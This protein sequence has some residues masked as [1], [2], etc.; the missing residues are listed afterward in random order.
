MNKMHSLARI[1]LVGL[2]VYMLYQLASS[3]LFTMFGVLSNTLYGS[4]VV[5]TVSLLLFYLCLGLAIYQLI[6]RREKWAEKIIGASEASGSYEQVDWL[7]VSFRLISVAGGIYCLS[8]LVT[9]VG[10]GLQRYLLARASQGAYLQYIF[11]YL[12]GL[13]V[14]LV[15]TIYLLCGAPH[16]VRWQMK[17]TLAQCKEVTEVNS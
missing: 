5:V 14:L 13:V 1:V 4:S 7:R 9:A 2:G 16:F 17:K 8:R 15:M 6:Y 11:E 10:F 12:F 3:L